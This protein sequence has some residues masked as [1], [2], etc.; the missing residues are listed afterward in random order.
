MSDTQQQTADSTPA[1]HAGRTQ[2]NVVTS[3]TIAAMYSTPDQAKTDATQVEAKPEDAKK[4]E[5]AKP[6]EDKPQDGKKNSFQERITELVAKRKE[7]EAK[8]EAAERQ[9]QDLEERL[10]RLEAQPEPA[11]AEPKPAR[12]QFTSDDEYIEALTEW[13]ADQAIA[14]REQEQAEARQKSA[15]EEL[16]SSW[17]KRQ[18]AAMKEIED[19]AE[20]I[21]KSE[22]SLPG[23]LHQ[24]ILESD[25]GPHLA[26]YFAKHP[27]EA[28]RFAGMTPTSA[29][30]NLGK[31]EDQLADVQ[32]VEPRKP[33]VE[34]SKAPAPIKPVKEVAPASP[35]SPKSFEEYRAKREAELASKR[36]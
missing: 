16:A 36:R 1:R 12:A 7:A 8:A 3:E 34:I 25:I 15:Q 17:A 23:H 4:A 24:A 28:K 27:D 31:L 5:E 14:K 29:L 18:K 13:K 11:K 35:G 21:G 26:Y 22:V 33:S 9:R 10:K 30:R 32:D 2:P 19:Y 6:N 20:V